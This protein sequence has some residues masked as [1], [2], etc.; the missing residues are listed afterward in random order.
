MVGVER[1]ERVSEDVR[2]SV[3]DPYADVYQSGTEEQRAIVYRSGERGTAVPGDRLC[4]RI[5]AFECLEW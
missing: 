1:V 2:T 3:A 4:G 5:G